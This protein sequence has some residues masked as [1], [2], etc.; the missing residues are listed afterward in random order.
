VC[1][2]GVDDPSQD[3]ADANS[4]EFIRNVP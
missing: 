2:G 3:M 1:D 4:C